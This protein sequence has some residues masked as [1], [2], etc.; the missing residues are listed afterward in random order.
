MKASDAHQRSGVSDLFH[1]SIVSQVLQWEP[2]WKSPQLRHRLAGG[3]TCSQRLTQRPRRWEQK[4]FTQSTVF[5]WIVCTYQS[6]VF[7]SV[8]SC[9]SD[10]RQSQPLAWCQGDAVT[11]GGSLAGREHRWCEQCPGGTNYIYTRWTGCFLLFFVLLMVLLFS[12]D[13]QVKW[14]L[15]ICKKK[16]LNKSNVV[17]RVPLGRGRT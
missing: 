15:V 12:R 1:D 13:E 8:E 14:H 3:Q 7:V 11:P 4:I 17:M 10:G 5:N 9:S 6:R 16:K 2:E